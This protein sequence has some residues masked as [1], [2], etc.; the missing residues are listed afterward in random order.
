MDKELCGCHDG[1]GGVC[2]PCWHFKQDR[3]QASHSP[4]CE[5]PRCD[6]TGLMNP[7]LEVN[8]EKNISN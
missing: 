6:G 8:S 4:N 7:V 5:R 2:P 3:H 1:I